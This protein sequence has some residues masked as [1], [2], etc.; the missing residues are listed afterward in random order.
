MLGF[1]PILS[2]EFYHCFQIKEIWQRSPINSHNF[3]PPSHTFRWSGQDFSKVVTTP[4]VVLQSISPFCAIIFHVF[5][6]IF[7]FQSYR[8]M[9]TKGDKEEQPTCLLINM[10]PFLSRAI[11]FM[12]LAVLLPKMRINSQ[13]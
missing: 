6:S 2:V 11:N 13:T 1:W 12:S 4:P 7:K 3:S 10:D 5:S 8:E 9:L